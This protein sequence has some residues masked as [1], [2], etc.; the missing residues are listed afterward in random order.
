M[1]RLQH[2]VS[3]CWLVFLYEM[4]EVGIK[5]KTRWHNLLEGTWDDGNFSVHP[6]VFRGRP[7]GTSMESVK[8]ILISVVQTF[9]NNWC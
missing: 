6:G 2:K 5:S 7:M 4:Y 3:L 8:K 1:K 9:F